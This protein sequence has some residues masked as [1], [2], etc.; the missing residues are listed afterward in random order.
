MKEWEKEEGEEGEKEGEEVAHLAEVWDE[1]EEPPEL[2]LVH[3]EGAG[4]G[5]P[6][7]GPGERLAA[8]NPLVPATAV[9]LVVAVVFVVVVVAIGGPV[10]VVVVVE[11]VL[12]LPRPRLGE[13]GPVAPVAQLEG[14]VSVHLGGRWGGGRKRRKRRRRRE[15]AG[16]LL[17][18]VFGMVSRFWDK[19]W[20]WRHTL[21]P[22]ICLFQ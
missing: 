7:G 5:E 1:V 19:V 20:S 11:V 18:P 13:H 9:V 17:R 16:L 12:A 4:D 14:P 2:V 6:A 10:V 21:N 8:G 3:D 15:E 22:F